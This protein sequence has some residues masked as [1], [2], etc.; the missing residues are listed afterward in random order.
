MDFYF[1]GPEIDLRQWAL[2]NE[3]GERTIFVLDDLQLGGKLRSSLFNVSLEIM[4]RTQR[5]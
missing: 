5:D 4:Q 1:T 2:F 3:S